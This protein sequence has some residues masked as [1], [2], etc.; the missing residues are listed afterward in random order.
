MKFKS[1]NSIHSKS[2]EVIKVDKELYEIR[3]VK[4]SWPVP[5]K[6]IKLKML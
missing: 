4:K 5:Q 1:D 2:Y 6:N 3:A